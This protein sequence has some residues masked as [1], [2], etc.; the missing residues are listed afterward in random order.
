MKRV[1]FFFTLV[2]STAWAEGGTSLSLLDRIV[3]LGGKL[4]PVVVHFPIALILFGLCVELVG[5]FLGRKRSGVGVGAVVV[6]AFSAIAATFAGW[7]NASSQEFFGSLERTL[8]LHQLGGVSVAILGSVAGLIG[9]R[10]LREA[11]RPILVAVYR[12]LLVGTSVLVLVCAHYGGMMVHGEDYFT[13]V[14]EG[15]RLASLFE[16]ESD[17]AKA[18]LNPELLGT[19]PKASSK[20]VSFTEDVYPILE[21]TCGN[22]HLGGKRKGDLQLD[23]LELS[24]KG[25]ES[26]KPAL[27]VGSS[28]ESYLIHLV[29][30]LD[31]DNIMP[32]KGRKL[33]PEEIGVLR[34]WIDDGASYEG[35][36]VEV[37]GEKAPY[38]HRGVMLPQ[39]GETNPIDRILLPYLKR[40]EID[41]DL[42]IDDRTFLKRAY[43]DT[44]GILPTPKEVS[45]YLTDNSPSKREALVRRLLNQNDR[46][47]AHWL[48]FWNDALRNDYTGPGFLHGG[49]REVTYWL[50]GALRNNTPYN[51]MVS[52]LVSPT[53][54]SSVGFTKGILWWSQAEDVNPNEHPAMQAAQNIGQVFLGI[55]MKCAS[56]HDSFTDE[57]KLKDSYGLANVYAKKPL[58]IH[59]CNQPTGEI[60]PARFVIPELGPVNSPLSEGLEEKLEKFEEELKGQKLAEKKERYLIKA[61]KERM[62]QLAERLTSR[63][64]GRFARTFVNRMWKKLFGRGIVEPIDEMD[65]IPFNQ[66]LLDW[67]AFHF[68][69]SGFDIKEFLV[70]VM[71]SKAYARPATDSAP[72]YQSSDVFAGPVVRRVSAEQLYDSVHTLSRLEMDANRDELRRVLRIARAELGEGAP[73]K[74]PET[75]LAP[76]LRFQSGIIKDGNDVLSVDVDI[77]DAERLWLA[78]FPRH[79]EKSMMDAL[80]EKH[81]QVAEAERENEGAEKKKQG[82]DSELSEVQ[83]FVDSL[84]RA[85]LE[86][87]RV[88]TSTGRTI[89]IHSGNVSRIT[90]GA[91]YV[92]W[93]DSESSGNSPI[94]FAQGAKVSDGVELLPLAALRVNVK[95]LLQSGEKVSRFLTRVGFSA[96]FSSEEHRYE[97]LVLTDFEFRS[98]FKENTQLLWTLGRPKRE[99]VATERND[100]ASTV[101]ALEL[102]NGEEFSALI[103]EA[104]LSLRKSSRPNEQYVRN[105]YQQLLLRE[106]SPEEMALALGYAEGAD[107]QQAMS[108]ILWALLV[109]PEFQ[110]IT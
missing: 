69:E 27:K 62:V 81:R 103:Q 3:L 45:E 84:E 71:T 10:I 94:Q 59:E 7:F 23:S 8:T 43:L 57:W 108:D 56:C 73:T 5:V 39:N 51:D 29:S 24:L 15:T 35:H 17:G 9:L 14:F 32:N 106:P 34:A 82:S 54:G 90:S 67:L 44:I 92:R 68:A 74:L 41:T 60:V 79:K 20:K 11:P 47:A 76:K 52:E 37:S 64:N 36:E 33:T 61:R 1:A 96:P 50:Y 99:Q 91:D 87:P 40:H 38:Q 85:V 26:G 30:G 63:E 72:A 107:P 16:G 28:E 86:T 19:I 77:Q 65:S 66:D 55:N 75:E 110:L 2:A 70:L 83:N 46:Y 88:I 25:G 12:T 80:A 48:T 102:T 104:V 13:Q 21:E 78:I 100:V 18:M 109:S 93:A 22:C 31:P 53:S 6:G 49:R 105:L 42:Q 98:V 58:Q 97:V 101:Q 89:R 95:E 4:H